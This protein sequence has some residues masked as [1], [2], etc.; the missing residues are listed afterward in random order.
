MKS[1]YREARSVRRG[2]TK[3]CSMVNRFFRG[4]QQLRKKKNSNTSVG[5]RGYT[6]ADGKDFN[7]PD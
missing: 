3:N 5:N 4:L 1:G 6:D 7:T 2:L